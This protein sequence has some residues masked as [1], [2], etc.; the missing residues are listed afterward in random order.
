MKIVLVQHA[1]L[2]ENL[3]LIG[4]NMYSPFHKW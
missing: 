1:T 2:L 4:D 3:E